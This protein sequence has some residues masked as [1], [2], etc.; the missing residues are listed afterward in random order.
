[1]VLERGGPRSGR[2]RPAVRGRGGG[3]R[4][5]ALAR[6][7]RWVRP[8]RPPGRL[9]RALRMVR[10][11]TEMHRRGGG[12]SGGDARAVHGR[13]RADGRHQYEQDAEQHRPHR[14]AVGAKA[15]PL[16]ASR[17]RA[18]TANRRTLRAVTADRDRA[19]T[20]DGSDRSPGGFA[21]GSS[22]GW[23]GGSGSRSRVD[24]R[25]TSGSETAGRPSVREARL[26]TLGSRPLAASSRCGRLLRP[27]AAGV[28][29]TFGLQRRPSSLCG[30]R[31]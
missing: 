20:G 11:G 17:G 19:S 4:R 9:A 18:A 3:G 26:G 10:A 8:E 30:L 1:M 5:S 21:G 7:G 6:E 12:V 25:G 13:V 16:V 15:G 27:W 29:R 24:G 2:W 22:G 28:A 14:K 31:G 23:S